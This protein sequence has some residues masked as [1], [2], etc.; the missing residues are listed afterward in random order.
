MSS[1]IQLVHRSPSPDTAKDSDSLDTPDTLG[2][3]TVLCRCREV[4]SFIKKR[5]KGGEEEGRQG[6]REKVRKNRIEEGTEGGVAG[7]KLTKNEVWLMHTCTT[8]G[9][10]LVPNKS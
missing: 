7:G 1:L 10:D 4:D 9:G 3:Y 2:K 5:G 6:K 8:H